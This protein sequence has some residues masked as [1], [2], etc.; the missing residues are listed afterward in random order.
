MV[1][2]KVRTNSNAFSMIELIFAIVIIG[3]TV[4]SLPVMTRITT[5]G[6]ETGVVQEAI[7]AASSEIMGSSAGYWDDRSMEDIAMSHMSRV[8]DINASDAIKCEDNETNPRYRLRPGHVAQPLH[9]RCVDSKATTLTNG[10]VDTIW[11]A[12]NS[13]DGT[14]IFER[15]DAAA[16]V[17]EAVGYKQA[18]TTSM[19]VTS[20]GDTNIKLIEITIVDTDG[21]DVTTLRMQTANIGEIDYYKRRF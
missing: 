10:G 13:I 16:I 3:I 21:N 1:R 5:R 17:G 7:L 12:A 19:N 11:T 18:Y 9:R 2:I 8:I 20:L 14:F 15:S 6:V 4:L